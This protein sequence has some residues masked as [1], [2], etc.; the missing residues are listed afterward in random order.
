MSQAVSPNTHPELIS[1]KLCPFVQ[2][3]VITLLEKGVEYRITYI[4]LE[5]PPQWFLDISPLGKVPALRVG[6][7]VLFESAV[8]NEY[9]DEINPPSLHPEDPLRKAQNRAWIEFGSNLIG[10]QYHLMI[11]KEQAQYDEALAGMEKKLQQLEQQLDAGPFFNGD[12]FSLVDA[13]VAPV[14]MRTQ[15]LSG[16]HDLSAVYDKTPKVAA[17]HEALMARESVQKSVVEEFADE[18]RDYIGR[19]GGYAAEVFADT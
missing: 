15:L 4:D 17:W 14:F 13:A 11:A 2:R 19:T 7:E 5:N 18:M 3:S 16:W 9:L 8:I 10:D 1:F 12:R 6:E